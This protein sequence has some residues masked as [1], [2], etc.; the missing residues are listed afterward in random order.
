M[1]AYDVDG[2]GLIK[3]VKLDSLSHLC[4]APCHGESHSPTESH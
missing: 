2:S 1:S 3:Y 4:L